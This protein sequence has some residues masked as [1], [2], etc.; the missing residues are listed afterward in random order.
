MLIGLQIFKLTARAVLLILLPEKKKSYKFGKQLE[1]SYQ[2][3]NI[4]IF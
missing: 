3:Y 1:D 4:D 2:Y